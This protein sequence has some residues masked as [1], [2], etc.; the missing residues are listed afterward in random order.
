MSSAPGRE[1]HALLCYL[2]HSESG[3]GWKEDVRDDVLSEVS[4]FGAVFHIH[5]DATS[6]QGCVY[7]KCQAPQVAT[8]AVSTLHGRKYGGGCDRVHACGSGRVYACG[9]GRVYACGTTAYSMPLPLIPL[10]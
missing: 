4:K 6:P 2:V 1:N 8:A 9:C 7:V 3:A 10:L 5:V